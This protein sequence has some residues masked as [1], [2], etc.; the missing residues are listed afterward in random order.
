[1]KHTRTDRPQGFT[2]IET[3]LA[4]AIA[5][6][7]LLVV[8]SV[9][10]SQSDAI[11]DLRKTERELEQRDHTEALLRDLNLVAKPGVND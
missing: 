6:G 10:S 8:I 11:R 5:A 4:V 1:M 3:V 9:L 2:L 7:T